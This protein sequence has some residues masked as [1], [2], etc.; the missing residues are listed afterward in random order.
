MNLENGIDLVLT[1]IK[2]PVVTG[3]ELLIVETGDTHRGGV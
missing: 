2:M 1:D 3:I